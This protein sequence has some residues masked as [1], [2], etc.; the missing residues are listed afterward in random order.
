M[1]LET[2]LYKSNLVVLSFSKIKYDKKTRICLLFD[3]KT[4]ICLPFDKKSGFT[5]AVDGNRTHTVSHTPL[6]RAR[7]PV[8]PQPRATGRI[9]DYKHIETLCQY[10]I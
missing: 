5:G 4:R 7:L 9:D 1:R 2:F 6:K 8:P 3:K 10:Q